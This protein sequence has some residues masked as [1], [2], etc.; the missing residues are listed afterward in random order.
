M[1][2]KVGGLFHIQ[3]TI[4]RLMRVNLNLQKIMDKAIYI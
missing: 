3:L 2:L 1:R 4:V